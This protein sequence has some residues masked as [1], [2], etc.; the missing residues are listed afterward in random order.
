M[1]CSENELAP[2]LVLHL[3]PSWMLAKGGKVTCSPEL[4]VR[5]H[6]FFLV[7]EV[8]PK[9]CKL[10]PMYTEGGPGRIEISPIGRVGHPK[11][12]EGVCHYHPDQVWNVSKAVVVMAAKVASDQSLPGSRNMLAVGHVPKV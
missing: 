3:C 1:S 12:T 5:G 6:H 11:W 4:I 9:R 10:V 2:G 7:L 8:G